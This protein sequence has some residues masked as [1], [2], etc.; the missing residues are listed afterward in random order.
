MVRIKRTR[1][2]YDLRLSPTEL[3]LRLFLSNRRLHGEQ[4][5]KLA[6]FDS[7]ATQA[8]ITA[9]YRAPTTRGAASGSNKSLAAPVPAAIQSSA[10]QTDGPSGG[11]FSRGCPPE[12]GAKSP[13]Y[14]SISQRCLTNDL[15]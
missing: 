15:P 2:G 13:P 10:G 8:A 11:S 9:N 5:Q 4:N 7:L 3:D 14:E 1:T 6:A 12:S